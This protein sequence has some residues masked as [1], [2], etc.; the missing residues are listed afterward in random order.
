TLRDAFP[1]A[2]FVFPTASKRRATIYKRTPIN[3]W[4]DNWS[5]EHPNDREELQFEGLRESSQYIHGLLREEIDAV[6]AQNV[7]LGGL[8]QGCAASLVALLTWDGPPLAAAVGMCGWLPLRRLLESRATGQSIDGDPD[9]ELSDD[10]EDED[11]PFATDDDNDQTE[12]PRLE[13]FQHAIA[14][15]H[16]ELDMVYDSSSSIPLQ[17]TK[18]FLGH[19]TEDD[20]VS[21]TLGQEATRCLRALRGNV[22]WH[23]YSGL[24][25]WYSGE[26]LQD[27]VG[28]LQGVLT[29]EE[30]PPSVAM[31][32][33]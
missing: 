1:H 23:E 29:V 11:N 2:K 18:V 9:D 27:L 30:K 31:S 10:L 20:R 7:V 4:F 14:S 28:F 17:S 13:P 26:M 5:L 16:E 24:G 22:Q 33:E 15:L 19:G 3:Q 12:N 32:K 25:H 6:G 21:L 8:S